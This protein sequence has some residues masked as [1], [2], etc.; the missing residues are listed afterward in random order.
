MHVIGIFVLCTVEQMKIILHDNL[1][2]GGMASNHCRDPHL[3]HAVE[4]Q[5][6]LLLIHTANAA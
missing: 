6:Q 4:A 5:H 2:A 3:Q 1:A